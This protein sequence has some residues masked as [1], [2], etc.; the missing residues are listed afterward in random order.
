MI[1]QR[2]ESLRVTI[3][4]ASDRRDGDHGAGHDDQRGQ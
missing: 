3:I 4:A 1:G 2:F